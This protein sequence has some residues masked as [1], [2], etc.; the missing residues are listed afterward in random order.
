[1][2]VSR[3][4]VNQLSAE[5]DLERISEVIAWATN[6]ANNRKDKPASI[7]IKRED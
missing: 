5:Y 1:M 4:M 2:G 7:E 3:N 6:P